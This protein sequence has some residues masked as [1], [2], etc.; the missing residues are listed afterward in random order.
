V[1]ADEHRPVLEEADDR[2][3]GA[4]P[5]FVGKDLGRAIEHRRHRAVTGPKIDAD[6]DVRAH[7]VFPGVPLGWRN[8]TDGEWRLSNC[9]TVPSLVAARRAVGVARSYRGRTV[10]RRSYRSYKMSEVA[11]ET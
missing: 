1:V 11:Q 8:G 6:R 10:V 3:V 4:F 7:F 2:G 9:G 5:P